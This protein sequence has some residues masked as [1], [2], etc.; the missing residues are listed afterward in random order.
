M[1]RAF[2]SS[3]PCSAL[4]ATSPRARL[5]APESETYCFDLNEDW[6]G[7]AGSEAG[8]GRLN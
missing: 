6:R 5:I 7:R 3:P 4:P 2:T 8:A 1:H